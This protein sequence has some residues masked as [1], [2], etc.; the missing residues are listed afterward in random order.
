MCVRYDLVSYHL[1]QYHFDCLTDFHFDYSLY[2]E[3][4]HINTLCAVHVRAN[5][6]S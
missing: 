6:V 5:K 4:I 2:N 3:L 1:H